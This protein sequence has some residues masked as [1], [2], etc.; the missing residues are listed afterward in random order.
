MTLKPTFGNGTNEAT[1]G[2]EVKML[3]GRMLLEI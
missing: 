3:D 2:G 1:P